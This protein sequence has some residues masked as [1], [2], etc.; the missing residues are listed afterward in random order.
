MPPGPIVGL[1]GLTDFDR[2]LQQGIP[3]SVLRVVRAGVNL[4]ASEFTWGSRP[5]ERPFA[6]HVRPGAIGNLLRDGSTVVL[7]VLHRFWEPVGDFCRRLSYEV[8]LPA[9]ATG[10]VT[11]ANHT[12]FPFHHDEGGNLLVQ[13]VG[14][15]TWRLREPLADRPLSH[16][17]ARANKPTEAQWERISQQP[18]ALEVTLRPGDVLWIPR[19]WL[20]SGSATDE[21]SVHVAVGFVPML[22]RY[23]LAGQLVARLDERRAEFA[24]L[25]DEVPWGMAQRPELLTSVVADL[26]KE[27]TAI[28][29]LLDSGDAAADIAKEI[30]KTFLEPPLTPVSAAL[31]GPA[32]PDTAVVMVTESLFA[33]EGTGDGRVRLVQ[34]A[35]ALTVSGAAA[36]FVRTRWE[37]DDQEPWCARDLTPEVDEATALGVVQ[38]LLKAGIVRRLDRL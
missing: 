24:G 22:S 31:A 4:P 16:E 34:A 9:S 2:M 12:G 23:W 8:G 11:P 35:G 6:D 38:A 37:R 28:L 3:A 36:Q 27:L 5:I 10:F 30:R 26:I 18:P 15:K 1:L 17:T 29:P 33:V 14:S 21:P 13:T 32:D 19:G 25:R 7:D 20:H